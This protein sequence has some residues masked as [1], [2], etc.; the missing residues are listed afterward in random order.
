V[1]GAATRIGEALSCYRNELPIVGLGPQREFQNTK[2]GHIAYFAIGLRRAKGA[3][4]LAASA[5]YEFPDAAPVVGFAIGVL[6]SESFVVVIVT[7]DNDVGIAV[8]KSLPDRFELGIVAVLA[9][10]TN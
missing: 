2:G 3:E 4:I 10:G 7:V 5:S 1:A 9:A 6:G 8:I